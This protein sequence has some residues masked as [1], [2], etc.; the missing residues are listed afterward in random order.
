MATINFATFGSNSASELL[1]TAGTVSLSGGAL[2]VNPTTTGTGSAGLGG[3]AADGTSTNGTVSVVDSYVRFRFKYD[4]KPASND[5]EIFVIATTTLA[6]VKLSLRLNSAGNI[7]AYDSTNTVISTGT[8]VLQAGATYLIEVRCGTGASATWEVKINSVVEI[9]TSTANLRATNAGAVYLGKGSNRNGNTVDFW[10]KDLLWSDSGYPGDGRS[11]FLVPSA[12]GNYTGT[13]TATGA[14]TLWQAV[15]EF[16]NDGDTSYISSTTAADPY[17]GALPDATGRLIGTINCVKVLVIARNVT[18]GAATMKVRLRSATTD[19]DTTA[20]AM[21]TSYTARTKL[22]DTDPATGSAWLPG[23]VDG[24]E[25]GLVF[26]T[27]SGDTL[28]VTAV[29]LMVDYSP[30]QSPVTPALVLG[31]DAA[32]PWEMW[33]YEP[34]S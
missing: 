5:E 26:D 7:A 30:G 23:G 32:T 28:R 19:S 16:P 29:Y 12:N 21:A 31:K 9:G 2:H 6:S 34:E 27:P 24:A 4:T 33:E 13:F 10:Y 1:T 14:A 17:T 3:V 20:S 8:T 15:D 11:L 22:A 18:A 25:A